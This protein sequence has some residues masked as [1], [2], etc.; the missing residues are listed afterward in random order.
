LL[1]GRKSSGELQ[2]ESNPSKKISQDPISTN[3]RAPWHLTTQGSINRRIEVQGYLGIKQDFISKVTNAKKA[4]GMAQGVESLLSKCEALS[5]TP[6][7]TKVKKNK[8]GSDK[9]L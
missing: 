3:D 2:F 1:L 4:G 8:R 7:T 6:N 5:S 9:L